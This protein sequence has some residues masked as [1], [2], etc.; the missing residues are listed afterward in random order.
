MNINLIR[1]FVIS[2]IPFSKLFFSFTLYKDFAI[3]P[4]YVL[5]PV[6]ST[7]ALL[8]PL[9]ILVPINP[10]LEISVI[11]SYS[12]NSVNFSTGF[13]SPVNDAWSIN[14]SLVSKNLTSPGI[15]SPDDNF[16]I[17]PGTTF[18][19]STTIWFPSLITS[20]L[21]V[22]IFF[23]FLAALSDLVCSLN[24]I[25]AE[26]KTVLTIKIKVA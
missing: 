12:F 1:I 16:T 17:S 25:T 15:I 14:K 2:S 4:K 20:I 6:E 24:D 21:F 10:I 3:L 7:N 8:L 9:T 5:L 19:I 11:V 23:N 26:I 18:S 22:I 13:D